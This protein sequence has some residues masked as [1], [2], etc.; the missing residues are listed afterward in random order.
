MFCVLNFRFI[1]LFIFSSLIFLS[2]FIK[3]YFVLDVM[4]NKQICKII[5]LN[6]RGIVN[7]IKR[8]SIF[9]YLKDQNATF[10]FQ[11]ET[12]RIV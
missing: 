8:S 7:S 10:Y 5:F 4:S 1:Y 9:T 3:A 2:V 6:V 11:Q 12:F